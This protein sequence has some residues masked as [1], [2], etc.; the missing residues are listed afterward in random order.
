MKT[1]LSTALLCLLALGPVT[2]GQGT[3]SPQTSQ[4]EKDDIV[5]ISTEL[6][7]TDVRVFDK[8]GRFVD[9]LGREQFEVK[10]DGKPVPVSFFERVT[11]GSTREAM[12]EAAARGG[13]IAPPKSAAPAVPDRGRTVLF[14][15]DDLHMSAPSIEQTRKSI[16]RFVENEMALSDQVAIGS[17]SGKIGFLQQ[18]TDNKAVLRAAVSRITHIPYTVRDSENVTMTEYTA[19]KIDQGDRDALNYF[20]EELLKATTFSSPAGGLGPPPSSPFGGKTDRGRTQGLTREGAEKQVKERAQLLLKQSAAVTIGTLTSL[21]SLMRRS[22][23]L[24]GR[25]LVFFIS[26]GFYLNDLNTGFGDKLKRITDAAVRAGVVVYTLDAR[27]L[28]SETDVTSNKADP[29]G[30]LARA[31]TGELA[32][33][34]DA[35][36]ALAGDTGGRALLNSGDLT[37]IVGDALRETS[38][39]YL[40]AWKPMDDQRGGKFKRIEVSIPGR[41][42]LTVRLPRGYLDADARMLAEREESKA[43]KGAEGKQPTVTPTSAA[44]TP[45]AAKPSAAK[46]ADAELL[47]ALNNAYGPRKAVPTHLNLS[48]LDTPTSGALLTASV[49]VQTTGLTYGADGKQP[50]TVDVAGVILN[51][52]GKPANSF[53]TRLNVKPLPTTVVQSDAASVIYNYK[54]TLTP[55]LYQVRAA[56]RDEKSGLVGSAQ[57]WIEIPDLS[58]KRLTLSSLLVGGQVIDKAGQKTGAAA[59][60]GA[61]AAAAG[62]NAPATGNSGA[63]AADSGP[64]VQF[65]VDKHFART[66][67]LSFWIFIYNAARGSSG[68]PDVTAQVQ[69]FRGAEA[70]VNTPQRKLSLA[71]MND[72]ARIPYGGEFPLS[73]L[74][75]G[76][77]WLQITVADKVANTTATQRSFFDVE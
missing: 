44:A 49:Q 20:A 34:Q 38:S 70:I 5:R 53:K 43:A 27:G 18:F 41:P 8:S 31:N 55:G 48:Y 19:I 76:R 58:S 9:G 3:P 74:Q 67:R 47:S 14:F 7:Q 46:S 15:L 75:P 50:A 62:N 12:L 6:V 22:E 21:E 57:Q 25:K 63:A 4:E 37:K 60:G 56:A 23:Q 72:L 26:D 54:A 16:L 71:G 64:Q 24:P 42:D 66:S 1:L 40:L 68:Q 61:G 2:F 39:Y 52:Q 17:P 59:G 73:A 36:T 77:Y 28:V 30:R 69:V 11:V 32:A 45:D 65:S 13:N 51:D 33:S 29:M 10:V 35:L